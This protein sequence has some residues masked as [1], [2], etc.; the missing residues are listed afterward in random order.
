MI[1]EGTV[2]SMTYQLTNNA[3]EELD[4]ADKNEPFTYLHGA[5]QIVPGLENALAGLLVGSKKKVTVAPADGYG[6]LEPQLRTAATRSQF[7]EEQDIEVGMRFAA[8]DG[9]GNQIVFTITKIEGEDIEL[10]GNHPL[11]GETLHFDVEVL[12]IREATAEELAHGHAHGEHGHGHD[13]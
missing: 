4:R 13:H 9:Q 5:G 6:E 10:D 8:E 7:P 1:K 3:G 11:A 2:V 12:A